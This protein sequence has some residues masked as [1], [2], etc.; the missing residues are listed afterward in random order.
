MKKII[1]TILILL[2]V[3]VVAQKKIKITDTLSVV[4]LEKFSVPKDRQIVLTNIKQSTITAELLDNTFKPIS[5][6]K[7]I[8]QTPS[9]KE[10]KQKAKGG[11]GV[12]VQYVVHAMIENPGEYYIK[13][14]IKYRD[15]KGSGEATA[16]YKVTVSYPIVNNEISLRE[17]YFYSEQAT[18][19]FSTA[20]FSDPNGYSYQIIDS[21]NNVLQKG[22][23]PIV[24]LNDVMRN[25]ANLGK[26]LTVKGFYHGKQFYYKYDGQDYHKSE[27]SFNLNKPNL[28][29]FGDWKKANPDDKIAISAW[30]KNAMRFLYT[31]TG[32]TPNGFV[33]VYPEVKNFRF[34]GDPAE[35]FIQPKFS[36]AGNFLYVTFKLNNDFLSKMEDCSEQ[37][38]NIKIQF[39]T[40]FGEKVEKEYDGIILK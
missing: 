20:D 33:V 36:R 35:L 11:R 4:T 16:Y 5:K 26:T 13:I 7:D 14:N 28:E 9:Q 21:D 3:Q 2:S 40:Q 32:S 29:E 24:N 19:S 34:V 25:I 8:S 18:M 6:I 39:I 12:M 17:N 30:N 22:N 23:E 38:V 31:Y 37:E 15:E 1:L 10:I 27:W